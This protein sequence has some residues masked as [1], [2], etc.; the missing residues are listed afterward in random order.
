[1]HDDIQ[2]IFTSLNIIMFNKSRK[3]R[4]A[5]HA[6]LMGE[7]IHTEFWRGILKERNTG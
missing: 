2:D 1:M 7:D 3:V 6:V 5:E 4:W